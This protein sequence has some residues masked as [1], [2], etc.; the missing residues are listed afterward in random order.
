M[1]ERELYIQGRCFMK[2]PKLLKLSMKKNAEP[3]KRCISLINAGT[4]F[5]DTVEGC[6]LSHCSKDVVRAA[7]LAFDQHPQE[8]KLWLS[9]SPKD[10]EFIERAVFWKELLEPFMDPWQLKQVMLQIIRWY[11]HIQRMHGGRNYD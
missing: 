7:E 2:Y 11:I 6:T 9:F 3:E 1:T 4:G 5:Y 8:E 10:D